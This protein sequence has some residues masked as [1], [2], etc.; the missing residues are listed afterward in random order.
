MKPLKRITSELYYFGKGKKII[1]VN[2]ELQGD[3]SNLFEDCYN[4]FTVLIWKETVLKSHKIKDL[5]TLMNGWKD[6]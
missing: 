3:C 4:L 2:Q 6:E 1:E 5:V